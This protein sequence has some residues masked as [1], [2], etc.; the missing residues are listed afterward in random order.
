MAKIKHEIVPLPDRR[1]F[2]DEHIVSQVTGYALQ[3]LRT[4]R[5]QRRGFP[6]YK[7]DRS[8]RYDLDE[9]FKYMDDR[10]IDLGGKD[11]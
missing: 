5:H 9:C 10:K 6:Y 4:W 3:T 8:I 1:R 11:A 2:V 7:I